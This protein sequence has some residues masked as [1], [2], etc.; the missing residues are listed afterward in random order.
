MIVLFLPLGWMEGRDILK[1]LISCHDL[2]IFTYWRRQV[3]VNLFSAWKA[4]RVI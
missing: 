3:D 1:N 2:F 4:A